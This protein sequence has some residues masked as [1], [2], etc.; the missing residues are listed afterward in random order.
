MAT[1]GVV[2]HGILGK[3][4]VRGFMEH[5]T[6]K[7]HDIVPEL[8]THPLEEVAT[9]DI[10]FI[11]LPTPANADGTCNTTVIDDFLDEAKRQGWWRPESCLVIRS[12]VPVGYTQRQA[13]REQ[14]KLPL[15]HSPEFLTARCSIVDFQTPA[16]NIIGE[17]TWPRPAGMPADPI[18]T[19]KWCSALLTLH[20]LYKTRFPGVAIH[21]M[22]SNA[23]ELA[24]LACNTFFASKV[25]LFNLFAEIAAA[26]GVDWEDVRGGILS[27]GRI[28]HAHTLVAS[29]GIG[30]GGSCLPKDVANL[31]TSANVMGIDAEIIREVLARNERLRRPHDPDLAKITL[32]PR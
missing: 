14:F 26:A 5:C 27:D 10:V 21:R 29:P 6:V 1:L 22:H 12:T 8:A 13:A 25:T 7:V 19:A 28:A 16:R 11:A 20:D 32:P 4:I 24:K 3:S 30:F 15:L 23:S 2:G 18:Q 31:Y 17:P 9:C